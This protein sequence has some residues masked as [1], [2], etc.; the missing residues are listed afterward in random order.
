MDPEDPRA[1]SLDQ[2]ERMTPDERDRVVALL[3]DAD[4]RIARLG[5]RL[6]KVISGQ[7]EGEQLA[8]ELADKLA[9]QRRLREEEQRLREEEQGRREEA[10]RQLAEALAEIARLK[11]GGG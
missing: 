2:W 4:E 3:E 11:K 1:P 10:E 9:E 5:S 6:D 7:E 8:R